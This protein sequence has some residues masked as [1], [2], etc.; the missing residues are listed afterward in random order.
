MKLIQLPHKVCGM[1]C[2]VNGLEDLYEAQTGTRLPDWFLFYM[3]GMAGFA[4]IKVNKAPVPRFVGWGTVV[5]AQ[6]KLLGEVMG[7]RWSFCEGRSFK[8]ALAGVQG[9]IDRGVPVILGALDMYHLPY[10]T[11]FYHT[12]H[13]PIHY[14]LMVGYDAERQLVLVQDCA[15][16]GV[17]EVPYS[18]LRLAWDVHVPGLS[19]KNTF[20]AFEFGPE[21]AD[22]PTIA[23]RA[24]QIKVE[25][26][27]K[28]PVSMFGIPGMRKL[29]RELPG[30][31]DELG[32]EKLDLVLRQFVEYTGTPPMLPNRLTG[33]V[34]APDFHAGGRDGFALVLAQ[35]AAELGCPAWAEAAALLA[36]SGQRIRALTDH[37]VD[38]LLGTTRELVGA[39]RMVAE[40]ADL[41]E[42]AYQQIALEL[43]G[44]TALVASGA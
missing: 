42:Q 13:V 9:H 10:L 15:R 36:Q 30:W 43:R 38:Y 4:Y 12:F 33:A 39:A 1:T 26:M 29:A 16:P 18:D 27:L 14:I 37:L 32:A 8:T 3:S 35:L 2:M 44:E 17:Q 22:L 24:L 7:F 6:Y 11:K 19:L 5:K 40:I 31:P 28:P 41:E 21:V 34:D 23:R 20:F 25:V